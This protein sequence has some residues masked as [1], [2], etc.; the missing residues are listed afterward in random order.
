[1]KEEELKIAE[2][3]AYIVASFAALI[4][5][6]DTIYV[7][8][9]KQHDSEKIIVINNEPRSRRSGNRRRSTISPEISDNGEYFDV[10]VFDD[11][12]S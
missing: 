10:T 6:L 11:D 4:Y 12:S 9:S 8:Y 2:F 7:Y 3:I 5:V 1:M